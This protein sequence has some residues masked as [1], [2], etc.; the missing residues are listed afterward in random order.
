MRKQVKQTCPDPER[1]MCMTRRFIGF[2]QRARAEPGLRFNALMGLLSDPQG[3]RE[4]F[5]R[6]PANKAPGIDGVSKAQS[7]Q[8]VEQRLL[9][10]SERVGRLGYRPK[11]AR[12]AD[13]PKGGLRAQAIGH[14]EL[15]GPEDLQVG[16]LR[17]SDVHVHANV[18]QGCGRVWT[19]FEARRVSALTAK[20]IGYRS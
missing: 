6:Q 15:R 17:L 2:T 10:L 1:T 20:M 5:E 4:S 8:D 19:L 11:P 13:I 3:L 7:A 12:R 18:V 9:G 16:A 14:P